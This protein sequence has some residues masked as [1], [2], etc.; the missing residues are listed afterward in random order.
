MLDKLDLKI[1][2][3]LFIKLTFVLETFINSFK[4]FVILINSYILF[5]LINYIF[6]VNKQLFS[7]KDKRVKAIK[8]N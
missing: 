3:K 2:Y 8:G 7:L 1:T 6:T 4:A 5:D